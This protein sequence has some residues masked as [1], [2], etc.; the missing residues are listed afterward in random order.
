ML[1]STVQQSYSALM[2]MVRSTSALAGLVPI[3]V[4]MLH[5]AIVEP[6]ITA[7][8]IM[9]RQRYWHIACLGLFAVCY[10]PS[11]LSGLKPL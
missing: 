6:D 7:R 5:L 8:Q 4:F 1:L 3:G 10:S 11:L 9:F 2:F